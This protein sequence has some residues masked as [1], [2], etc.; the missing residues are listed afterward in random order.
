MKLRSYLIEDGNFLDHDPLFKNE[1][2][3]VRF[4]LGMNFL[5]NKQLILLLLIH[6]QIFTTDDT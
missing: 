2:I 4:L 5:E 6:D 3:R 1:A